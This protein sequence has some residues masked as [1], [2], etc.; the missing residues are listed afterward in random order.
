MSATFAPRFTR[1]VASHS[2]RSFSFAGMSLPWHARQLP[3]LM[4][5]AF[6]FSFMTSTACAVAWQ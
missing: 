5:K 2:P 1:W 4:W 3:S 6:A